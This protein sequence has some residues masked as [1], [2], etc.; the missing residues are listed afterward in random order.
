MQNKLELAF[1]SMSVATREKEP[2]SGSLADAGQGAG[3]GDLGLLLLGLVLAIGP[4][5][6]LNMGL[7][8]G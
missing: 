8:M 3:L 5:F 6:E 2:C 7:K 1:L 4:F